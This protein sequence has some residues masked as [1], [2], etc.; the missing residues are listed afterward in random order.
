MVET[1][2]EAGIEGTQVTPQVTQGT[3]E[4][5]PDGT[6]NV[7]PN[8][9]SNVPPVTPESNPKD[10]DLVSRVSKFIDGNNK[11]NDNTDQSQPFSYPEFEKEIASIEDPEKREKFEQLRKSLMRGANDKF[12]E[13]AE[14]RKE[15]KSFIDNQAQANPSG[16]WTSDK[17]QA[18]L[19]DPTFVQAANEVSGITEPTDDY[20]DETTRKK[21]SQMES[22]LNALKQQN[23]NT[24]FENQ[25]S[26]LS[27][28]YNNYDRQAVDTLRGDLIANKVHATNEHLWKVLDYEKAMERAYEIG[29]RDGQSDTVSKVNNS[30]IGVNTMQHNEGSLQ[31]EE[32]EKPESFFKRIALRNL[33]ASRQGNQPRT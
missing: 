26:E 32:G 12:Q 1:L 16:S 5:N 27:A 28:K 19:N 15:M 20:M 22:E 7:I 8:V 17:V 25:H 18:L 10:T 21:F 24:V 9:T 29:K 13:I 33:Q 3:P 4:V 14:L 2:R 30:S 11:D 6:P 23:L 31:K